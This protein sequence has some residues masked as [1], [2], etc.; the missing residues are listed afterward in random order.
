MELGL[1]LDRESRQVRIS[2]EVAGRPQ[3]LEQPE[4][5][6]AVAFARVE[7][8]DLRLVQ[9]GARVCARPPPAAGWSGLGDGS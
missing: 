9:P 5:D 3:G 6:L 1:V 2:R 4:Q 7:N 8:T